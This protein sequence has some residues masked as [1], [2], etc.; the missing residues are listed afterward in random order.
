MIL[1]TMLN[2][3]FV[4]DEILAYRLYWSQ[5]RFEHGVKWDKLICHDK[6]RMLAMEL[7]MH[8]FHHFADYIYQ[9]IV[10]KKPLFINLRKEGNEIE[11]KFHYWVRMMNKH[12]L[13]Y[14]ILTNRESI[15]KWVLKK[16]HKTGKKIK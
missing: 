2:G 14:D 13:D 4:P 12:C 10:L 3:K 15:K 9:E 7:K 16:K 1:Q 8:D 5:Q 6:D 11:K